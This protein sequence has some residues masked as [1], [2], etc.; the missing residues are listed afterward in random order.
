LLCSSSPIAV[1]TSATT[2]SWNSR[3]PASAADAPSERV[4]PPTH[5]RTPMALASGS[6]A[7][8]AASPCFAEYALCSVV[9]EFLIESNTHS[10]TASASAFAAW[11]PISEMPVPHQSRRAPLF[12]LTCMTPP[13]YSF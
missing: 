2:S 10:L 9:S 5:C 6:A 8:A 12:S 13:M 1:F 3:C 4:T 7:A 11:S